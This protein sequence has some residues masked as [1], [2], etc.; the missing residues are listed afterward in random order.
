MK[1]G[2]FMTKRE[3]EREADKIRKFLRTAMIF[4]LIGIGLVAVADILWGDAFLGDM[5]HWPCPWFLAGLFG[6]TLTGGWYVGGKVIA[7]KAEESTQ[8]AR[9]T[10]AYACYIAF[11]I[12]GPIMFFPVIIKRT[13]QLRKLENQ[14]DEDGWRG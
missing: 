1:E 4:F 5:Q 8:K 11:L 2:I 7:Q 3:R 10:D 9:L 14:D 12:G 13:L 6:G